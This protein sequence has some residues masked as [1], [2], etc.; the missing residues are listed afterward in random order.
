MP[1]SRQNV[2]MSVTLSDLRIEL[3]QIERQIEAVRESLRIAETQFVRQNGQTQPLLSQE[4]LLIARIADV[5]ASRLATTP[6]GANNQTKKYLRE[7][8][9]AQYMGISVSALRS[10]RTHRSSN[11]PPYTRL[12]R[13]VLHPVSGIEEHMRTRIVRPRISPN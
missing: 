11:G 4:E 8:E 2:E 13:M 12:G 1:Q 5:V 3:L 10:W 9:A 7:R 6:K